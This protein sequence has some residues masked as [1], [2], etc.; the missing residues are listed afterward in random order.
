M[1][2][3]QKTGSVIQPVKS[4]LI[5]KS[6]AER[7]QSRNWKIWRAIVTLT[8]CYYCASM[9]GK[10][11]AYDN[12]ELTK[13]PVHPNCRCY[14]E[15]LD[16]IL[17]GTATSNGADGVDLY[18]AIH[19]SLPSNY[20]RKKDAQKAGWV[21]L[22]GNLGDILPGYLIGGDIYWNRDGRLPDVPGR[23]WHEADFDYDGG[24]R[25]D[26]RLLYS[27][28]GLIFITYDHYLS[29]IEIILEENT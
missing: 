26:C 17:A 16:A 1:Y 18:V 10:I 19:N 20:M 21:P 25:N 7:Y 23:V 24:Y 12:P 29:F 4:N 14:A 27:N 13:I 2:V 3:V 28:D 22:L 9:N 15:W 5:S 6:Q 11:L 8:I